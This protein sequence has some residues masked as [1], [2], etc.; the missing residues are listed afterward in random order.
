MCYGGTF[1]TIISASELGFSR[2]HPADIAALSR[3]TEALKEAIIANPQYQRLYHHPQENDMSVLCGVIVTDD[4]GD[5]APN[6][7]TGAELGICFFA[8]QQVDRS[9]NGSGIAAR[10]ALAH[11]KGTM[12]PSTRWTYHS[13]LSKMHNGL[14]A[15][16]DHIAGEPAD[17]NVRDA[18]KNSVRV[19]IEGK[20][21]Y[22]GFATFL[23]EPGD[24]ISSA[25]FAL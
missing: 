5:Y 19:L 11:A 12:Q 9:P 14:G 16:T 3:A 20:A 21:F 18:T 6:G 10:R 15:F 8:N 25:G 17:H 13:F 22:T 24:D 1:Y 4:R 2:L 23:V 7:A